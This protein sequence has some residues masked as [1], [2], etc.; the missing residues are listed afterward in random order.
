[1]GSAGEKPHKGVYGLE[2]S[3]RGNARQIDSSLKTK[4]LVN[5]HTTIMELGLCGT[6]I[7]TAGM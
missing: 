5:L 6:W 3:G 7:N 4:L 1:V 2:L